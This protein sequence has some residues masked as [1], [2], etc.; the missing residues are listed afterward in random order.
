MPPKA[1]WKHRQKP[2]E[3]VA[4][5]AFDTNREH[6]CRVVFHPAIPV[7]DN[8][9]ICPCGRIHHSTA[10]EQLRQ[11]ERAGVLGFFGNTR[12]PGNGKTPKAYYLTR[13][14]WEL[15]QDVVDIPPELLGES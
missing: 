2:G 6:H 7:L 9:S 1:S 4:K 12:L 8:W 13:K 10:S 3:R 11:F 14:G 5:C 15:L